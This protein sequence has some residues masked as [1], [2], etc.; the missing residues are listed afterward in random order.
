MP[1][2]FDKTDETYRVWAADE[3]SDEGALTNEIKGVD[4]FINY[5]TR[6]QRV[7]DAETNLLEFIIKIFT[8]LR[9]NYSEPDDYLRLRY[10]ALL[11]RKGTVHWNGKES[12]RSVLSYFFQE[13]DIYLIERYPVNNLIVNGGFDAIDDSWNFNTSDAEFKLIYSRSFE[14]GS[15]MYINPAGANSRAFME[16]QILSVAA[17]LYE[18]IFFFPVPKRV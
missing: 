9:R 13:K 2:V 15:A 16:Q 17:G 10:K 1:A 5:Y 11:E 4:N 6:A 18:F 8:G 7:D 3:D 12:I 14:G